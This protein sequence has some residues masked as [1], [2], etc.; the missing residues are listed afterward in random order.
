MA[1]HKKQEAPRCVAS[2]L[3]DPM[4]CWLRE[5]CRYWSKLEERCCYLERRAAEVETAKS[6]NP[7]GGKNAAVVDVAESTVQSGNRGQRAG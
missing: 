6:E 1:G 3:A 2:W 4:N 7:G 5:G